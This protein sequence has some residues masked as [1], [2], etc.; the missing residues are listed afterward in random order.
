MENMDAVPPLP[1][2]REV[3]DQIAA[4]Q[5]LVP[6]RDALICRASVLGVS[7]RAVAEAA[8]I[9]S[10]TVQRICAATARKFEQ[11]GGGSA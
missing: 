3:R 9:T 8:G 7:R 1:R 10:S 2:L 5:A 11:E 4:A 6:E